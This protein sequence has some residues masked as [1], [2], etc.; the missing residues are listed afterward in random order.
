[1]CKCFPGPEVEVMPFP[2]VQSPDFGSP[3]L[4]QLDVSGVG[5]GTVLA[6]GE[7]GETSIA[8]PQQKTSSTEIRYCGFQ[9]SAESDF[10]GAVACQH[11]HWV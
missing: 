8:L 11:S 7:P 9:K 10:C 6:Q 3:F 1:M 2:C 5:T 4:V